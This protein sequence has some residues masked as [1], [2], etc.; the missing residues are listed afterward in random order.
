V[1]HSICATKPFGSY[2][3]SKRTSVYFDYVKRNGNSNIYSYGLG[4]L[5]TF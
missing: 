5:H 1:H 2:A 4:V 3:L